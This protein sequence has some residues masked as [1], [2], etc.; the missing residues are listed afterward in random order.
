MI[1]LLPTCEER[2]HKKY[3]INY[4]VSSYILLFIKGPEFIS[5][6][7]ASVVLINLCILGTFY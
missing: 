4:C 3:W 5:S 7:P 1:F 6:S 2:K